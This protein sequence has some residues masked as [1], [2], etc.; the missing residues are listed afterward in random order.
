MYEIIPECGL[1]TKHKE[2]ATRTRL[3]RAQLSELRLQVLWWAVGAYMG[4]RV[5][6]EMWHPIR[7][8]RV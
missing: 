8:S 3:P 1:E 6:I 4:D 7:S 2:K 5:L